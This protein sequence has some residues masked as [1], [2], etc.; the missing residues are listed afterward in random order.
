M[1]GATTQYSG[2]NTMAKA[3]EPGIAKSECE[4]K[5]GGNVLVLNFTC[6]RVL[7]PEAVQLMSVKNAYE[8]RMK[9][10]Y[11]EM[12]AAFPRTVSKTAMYSIVPQNQCP[13]SS[14]DDC[15][16]SPQK[17]MTEKPNRICDCQH[18]VQS[19]NDQQETYHT[20][21]ERVSNPEPECGLG[22]ECV[23]LTKH[24]QLGVPIQNTSRDELVE[25][26]NDEGRQ[27]GEDDVI[28]RE[29]P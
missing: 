14:P 2:M 23:A 13:E 27:D 11:S 4:H 22:E 16:R 1:A 15:L 8:R 24:V 28:H 7:R 21:V 3:N 17:R 25:D 12:R 20:V 6:Y 9:R 29:R 26:T 5:S 18:S 10:T 19:G